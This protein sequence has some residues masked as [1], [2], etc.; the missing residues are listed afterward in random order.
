MAKGS[1]GGQRGTTGSIS[2]QQALQQ[3]QPQ[4]Q[5]VE[6]D[7]TQ[8]A[9]AFDKDY[10][11]F[12]QMTE[13]E[14]VDAISNAIQNGVPNHLSDSSFQRMIYNLKFNDKPQL[15][16]D[17]TLD[18]MN[19]TE[20]F[21]T[22]NSVYDKKNDLGY[23]A[24]E[25]AK[26]IQTGSITRTSDN[27]GSVFGRGIYFADD[28]AHSTRNYG[29]TVNDVNE[30]AVVRAKLNSNAKVISHTRAENGAY[31][32]IRSG[33][34]LGQLLKQA[35]FDSRPSI[36]ATIKGYNVI[37]NGTGYYVVLNRRAITMSKTIKPKRG[38]NW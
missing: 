29:H 21:R 32:E 28:Y 11:D 15:V 9:P 4:A 19:G 17:K 37:E 35:D 23:S 36:F 27:G 16:D 2:L 31:N 24:T 5:N 3:I 38:N 7:D 14:K 22:V 12:I 8:V 6:I 18:T 25:I 34:K 20:F 26:Q 30:T 13:D 10:N 1:R 33:S